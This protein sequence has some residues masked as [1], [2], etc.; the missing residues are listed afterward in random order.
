MPR[1]E[2]VIRLQPNE[3]VFLKMNIKAPGLHTEPK[4]VK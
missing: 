1:N 2:L 4:Q 3:G